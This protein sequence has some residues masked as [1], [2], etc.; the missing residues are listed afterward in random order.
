M[1]EI[2][3]FLYY[4][5]KCEGDEKVAVVRLLGKHKVVDFN[6][7]NCIKSLIDVPVKNHTAYTNGIIEE[8]EITDKELAA[9]MLLL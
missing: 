5:D 3:I 7:W 8:F 1:N 2:S 9:L 6:T 4:E